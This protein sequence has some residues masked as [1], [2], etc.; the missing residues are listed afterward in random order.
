MFIE[1]TVFAA[2]LGPGRRSSP[3]LGSRM[4][5][6]AAQ[7]ADLLAVLPGVVVPGAPVCRLVE[8]FAILMPLEWG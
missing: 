7:Q 5:S 3:A 8:S 4:W 6:R 1:L 2:D